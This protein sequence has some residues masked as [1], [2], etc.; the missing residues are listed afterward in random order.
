MKKYAVLSDIHGNSWALKAV[1]GDI[2]AREIR[3]LINL[4]DIFYG[5]LDPAGTA[6][7]LKEYRMETVRGNEDRIIYETTA[8]KI[9]NPTLEYVKSQLSQREIKW[10]CQLPKAAVVDGEI[11]CCH[12]TPES[13][14]E[15]LLEEVRNNRVTLRSEED[16]E[17]LVKGIDY[18]VIVC[19][20]SHVAKT[21]R[22]EDG[23]VI[24]N[25][26]SV[27]LPAY[28]DD[29]P[30]FHRMEAGTPHASYVILDKKKTGWDVQTVKVV[31]DWDKAAVLAA[32]NGR[33][34]WAQWLRT[35]RD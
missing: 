18:P 21:L 26:G 2:R 11:F 7:V 35:G 31:Y 24:V 33:K 13:D 29:S 25:A 9:K 6:D 23:R 28:S 22:L 17:K 4:G 30:Q 8:R 16:I 19:G 34:D 5:P 32:E 15:Y 27:G 20:H 3:D 14:T 10:L 12:G 1:L